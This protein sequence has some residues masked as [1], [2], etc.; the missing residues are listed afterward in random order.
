MIDIMSL[1]KSFWTATNVKELDKTSN[2]YGVIYIFHESGKFSY[3]C[4]KNMEGNFAVVDLA[5]NSNAQL[6]ATFVGIRPVIETPTSNI[7]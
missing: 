2:F 1:T 7:K 5:T 4:N 6:N 3:F